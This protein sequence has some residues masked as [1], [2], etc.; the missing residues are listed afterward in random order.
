MRIL[1]LP[2]EYQGIAVLTPETI[3]ASHA[4]GYVIWVWPTVK[5]TPA[6]YDSLLADGLDGLNAN[7]PVDAIAAVER[8]I[9]A[10]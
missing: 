7:Y 6:L 4:A 1:Q 5:E 10:S 9:A 8:S 2:P 3:A